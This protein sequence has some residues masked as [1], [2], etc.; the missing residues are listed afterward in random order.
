MAKLELKDIS[1]EDLK[2]TK[3]WYKSKT[4]WFNILT[5]LAAITA[6]VAGLIPTLQPWLTPKIYTM[7]IFIIGMINVVLRAITDSGIANDR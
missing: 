1:V 4:I 3:P 5:I 7:T 2:P 6:G